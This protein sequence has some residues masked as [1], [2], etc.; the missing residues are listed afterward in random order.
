MSMPT[1]FRLSIVWL[2]LLAA[3]G[4]IGWLGEHGGAGGLQTGLGLLLVAF[5]K[6]R[7]VAWDFMGLSR[8]SPFWQGLMLG[9]LVLVLFLIAIAFHMGASQ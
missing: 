7:F 6:C 2:G 8:A 9:W 4:L 3:T 5:L 1:T